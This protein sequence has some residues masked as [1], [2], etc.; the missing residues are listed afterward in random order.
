MMIKQIWEERIRLILAKL[1]VKRLC[2]CSNTTLHLTE[3][4]FIH[5]SQCVYVCDENW[6]SFVEEGANDLSLILHVSNDEED[7]SCHVIRL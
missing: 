4:H 3:L 1:S 6:R 7:A 2:V 5:E